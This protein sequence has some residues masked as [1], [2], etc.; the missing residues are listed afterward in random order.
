MISTRIILYITTTT[1]KIVPNN[2]YWMDK[3]TNPNHKI[4]S[5]IDPVTLKMVY[6]KEYRGFEM[7]GDDILIKTGMTS[8]KDGYKVKKVKPVKCMNTGIVYDS[9]KDAEEG[10]GIPASMV[11]RI[12]RG[13]FDSSRGFIFKYN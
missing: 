9:P 7:Y 5:F 4:V 3:V 2:A 10:T 6:E 1:P 8:H 13:V 11:S 12:A